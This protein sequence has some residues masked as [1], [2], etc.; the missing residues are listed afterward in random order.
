META[1]RD[2]LATALTAAG[3]VGG[4]TGA[5]LVAT[6][7]EAFTASLNGVALVAAVLLAAM[8]ILIARLLRHVPSPA[9]HPA[10]TPKEELNKATH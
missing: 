8:A 5:A 6:A 2:T 4:E 9:A 1:S 3:Q 10:P 7:R